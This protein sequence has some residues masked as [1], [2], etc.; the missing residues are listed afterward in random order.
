M[1]FPKKSWLEPAKSKTMKAEMPESALQD[2]TNDAL[3]LRQW[4]YL[5]F[6]DALL[7]WIRRNAPTWVSCVFFKQVA[8]KLPDNLILLKLGGGFFL[9]AKLELKTQDKHG[10]AV[11]KTHG[12]QKRY[13]ED[14]EWMIARSPEQINRALDQIEM[15]RDRILS[16]DIGEWILEAKK[17]VDNA[18]KVDVSLKD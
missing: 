5:R 11:G 18:L 2:Y 7:G 9:G 4:A 12:K 10:R 1:A 8:G 15:I 14:E 6:P 16:G 3:E 17:E 13:A